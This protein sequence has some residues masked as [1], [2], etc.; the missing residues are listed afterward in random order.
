[1]KAPPTAQDIRDTTLV[2]ERDLFGLS[3]LAGNVPLGSTNGFGL[4]HGDT[5][6]LSTFEL[7]IQ[8]LSPTVLLSSG[9]WPYLGSYVS[10]PRCQRRLRLVAMMTGPKSITSYA[11]L[12]RA[13][14]RCAG[15]SSPRRPPQWASGALRRH[16]GHFD[17]A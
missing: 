17:A 2:K 9:R 10:C 6:F 11:Q 16:A 8:G 12:L 14:D 15:P 1:V 13:A 3:D 5:R 7:Q 4:Y